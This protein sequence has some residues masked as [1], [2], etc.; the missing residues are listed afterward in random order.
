[1]TFVTVMSF[2]GRA[3]FPSIKAIFHFASGGLDARELH[4][5]I[6]FMTEAK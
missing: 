5:G 6:G 4:V 3:Q 1:M 2:S